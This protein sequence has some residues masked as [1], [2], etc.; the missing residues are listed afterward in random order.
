MPGCRRHVRS[1]SSWAADPL[2]GHRTF[3]ASLPARILVKRT[4]GDK[5]SKRSTGGNFIPNCGSRCRALT[6]NR[7]RIANERGSG[8]GSF[9]HFG[10]LPKLPRDGMVDAPWL[11]RSLTVFTRL[12]IGAACLAI[13]A[14]SASADLLRSVTVHSA[15]P[16]TGIAQQLDCLGMTRCGADQCSARNIR[17]FA[18]ASS[19]LARRSG[20]AALV[21]EL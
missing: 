15:C 3:R 20:R 9:L 8:G 4:A 11:V 2:Q 12:A 1:P 17:A 21:S 16:G 19:A 10:E 18:A 13:T 7:I 5:H 6:E 14:A